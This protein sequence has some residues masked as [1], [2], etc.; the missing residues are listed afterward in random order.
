M[1]MFGERLIFD[2]NRYLNPVIDKEYTQ[3][4]NELSQ[5]GP[6]RRNYDM[7]SPKTPVR[8]FEMAADSAGAV[9]KT[10]LYY[11]APEKGRY[12]MWKLV[13]HAAVI[14]P[15]FVLAFVLFYF[16]RKNKQLL[17]LLIAFMAFAFWMMFHLLGETVKFVM[18]EYRNVAIYVILVV[19]AAVFGVLAY[20][21]QAKHQ[22][23]S[24]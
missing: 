16:K 12:M 14:I 6:S 24:E 3:W 11:A 7:V 23:A 8:S 9:S 21:T 13:I 19:L 4:K 10:R 15:L 22:K 5:Q 17:P 18:D 2:L 1:V 20:Y